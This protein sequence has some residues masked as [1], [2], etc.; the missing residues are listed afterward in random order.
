MKGRNQF[1]IKMRGSF[2]NV[3]VTGARDGDVV[4]KGKIVDTTDPNTLPQEINRFLFWYLG[5]VGSAAVAFLREHYPASRA[6]RSEYNEF[7]RQL[8]GINDA[9]YDDVFALVSA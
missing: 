3:T 9:L 4:V 6:T 7:M 8:N 1:L 2:E 5:Q